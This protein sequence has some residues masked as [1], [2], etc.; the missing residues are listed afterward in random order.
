MSV[1]LPAPLTPASARRSP[2]PSRHVSRAAPPVAEGDGHTLG[3]EHLVAQPGGG[4]AQELHPVAD[5]GLVGDE[6]VGRLDAELRLRGAGG[7]PAA[8]PR[9]LLAQELL[10]AGV[11]DAAWRSRSARART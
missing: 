8:Q 4:E 6:R 1:V 11:A 7:R 10:A 9:E 3:V 5:L 2:G